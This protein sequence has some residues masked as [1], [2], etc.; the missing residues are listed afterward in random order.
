MLKQILLVVMT[1]ILTACNSP[2]PSEG[3]VDT[4]DPDENEIKQIEPLYLI[5]QDPFFEDIPLSDTSYEKEIESNGEINILC[6]EEGCHPSVG[7]LFSPHGRCEATL[8]SSDEVVTATHCL[9]G[10]MDRK[11]KH[12]ML[13]LSN[14]PVC[15]DL[16][17]AFPESAELP[18]EI[19]S[20]RSM[21]GS[22]DLDIT[23][24]KLKHPLNRPHVEIEE[25]SGSP[26]KK[27]VII[28]KKEEGL[29]EESFLYCNQAS[30]KHALNAGSSRIALGNCGTLKGNSGA[31]FF[32]ENGKVI[33]TLMGTERN[34]NDIIA[35][36]LCIEALRTG[37][38]DG[39][40][41]CLNQN[42]AINTFVKTQFEDIFPLSE[43]HN[44]FLDPQRP[45]YLTST[46]DCIPDQQLNNKIIEY[47]SHICRVTGKHTDESSQYTKKNCDVSFNK[48]K[49]IMDFGNVYMVT[50]TT[51]YQSVRIGDVYISYINKCEDNV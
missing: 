30:A 9:Q 15:K 25:S 32:N 21:K 13:F 16:F 24:I 31:P 10:P 50:L 27:I 4:S 46:P 33:G 34:S 22:A 49:V 3:P 40:R 42:K 14:Q 29:F 43:N 23:V 1:V 26:R 2:R 45:L 35:S 5:W 36:A 48:L 7:I 39:I 28:N 44:Y 17:I 19:A 6:P 37:S 12:K 51:I 20:C 47:P 38:I 18:S 8:I 11:D 41:E